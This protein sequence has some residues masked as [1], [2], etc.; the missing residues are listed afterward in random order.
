MPHTALSFRRQFRN[1]MRIPKHG[2]CVYQFALRGLPRVGQTASRPASYSP[3]CC[4][5]RALLHRDMADK[6][7]L[8]AMRIHGGPHESPRGNLSIR[9]RGCPHGRL[10]GLRPS[11]C[12]FRDGLGGFAWSRSGRSGSRLFAWPPPCFAGAPPRKEEKSRSSRY[13]PRPW[14]EG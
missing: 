3:S 13:G 5:L 11:F 12:A 6:D 8:D 14:P 7:D 2:F 1:R 9:S 4:S 10:V